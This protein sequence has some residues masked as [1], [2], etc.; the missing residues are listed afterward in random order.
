MNKS[1]SSLIV[2][3][4]LCCSSAFATQEG[5]QEISVGSFGEIKVGSDV[6]TNEM[7]IPDYK[8]YFRYNIRTD[9]VANI[10]GK[11]RILTYVYH[12]Y[13]Y[14]T[15]KPVE[16]RIQAYSKTKLYKRYQGLGNRFASEQRLCN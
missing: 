13:N 8:K 2:C 15:I 16:Y 9:E 5:G 10:T 11:C 3:S 14:D 1:I 12:D 4:F 6:T 7:S